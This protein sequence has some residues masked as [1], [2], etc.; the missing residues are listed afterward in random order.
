MIIFCIFLS[1]NTGERLVTQ[2]FLVSSR[3]VRGAL[4]DDTKNGCVANYERLGPL[5]FK[6]DVT[7]WTVCLPSFFL[8]L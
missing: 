2:Q 1:F 8:D 5:E 6:N 4:R 3:N 7:K